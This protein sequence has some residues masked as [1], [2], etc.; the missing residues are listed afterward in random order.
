MKLIPLTKGQ[1]AIVDDDDFEWLSEWKWCATRQGHDRWRAVRGESRFDLPRRAKYRPVVRMVLMHRQ[2]LGATTGQSVD[3]INGDPL[4]N[5]RV[6]LRIAT[7]A[8]NLLNKRAAMRNGRETS[9]YKGVSLDRLRWRV[10]FKGKYI[11]W[12]KDEEEAARAY[13]MAAL[14]HDA[15]FARLNFPMGEV[16]HQ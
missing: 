10:S 5:R 7:Q 9:K 11:G 15:Q 16:H 6:N 2:I 14:Q 13:D 12:F 8:Q 3:H 1:F 4:D